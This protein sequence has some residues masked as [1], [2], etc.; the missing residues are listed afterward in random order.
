MRKEDSEEFNVIEDAPD[1]HDEID[2]IAKKATKEAFD[3]AKKSGVAVTYRVKN[4]IIKELPDGN[5]L[6]IEIELPPRRKV[7]KGARG[8]L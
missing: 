3:K 6:I 7:K 1:R 2:K 5:S 4:K 8:K